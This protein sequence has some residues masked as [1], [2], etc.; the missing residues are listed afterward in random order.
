MIDYIDIVEEEEKSPRYGV[1]MTLDSL[2]YEVEVPA[3]PL[4][5]SCLSCE[6]F[7]PDPSGPAKKS[8]KKNESMSNRLTSTYAFSNGEYLSS[9][10]KRF[11]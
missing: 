1:Y 11:L 4:F 3:N 10:A 7:L 9:S 8:F 6:G 5:A 2:S